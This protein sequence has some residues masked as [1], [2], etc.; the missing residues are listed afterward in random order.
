M[1]EWFDFWD[2]ELHPPDEGSTQEHHMPLHD[3]TFGFLSPTEEQ[4]AQMGKLRE[5]AKVYADAVAQHCPEGPDKTYVLRKV[6]ECAMWT[7]VACTRAADGTPLVQPA[8]D[9]SK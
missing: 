2:R 1:R 6:R 8:T 9:I 7:N 3:S 5:A 4:K